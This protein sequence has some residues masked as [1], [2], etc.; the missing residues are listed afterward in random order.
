MSNQEWMK[1]VKLLNFSKEIIYENLDA[2]IIEF[3]SHYPEYGSYVLNKQGDALGTFKKDNLTFTLFTM[4]RDNSKDLVYLFSSDEGICIDINSQMKLPD[5]LVHNFIMYLIS[6][7]C[8]QVFEKKISIKETM[9]L[10]DNG[11]V[12]AL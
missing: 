2:D 12:E 7:Y 4:K 3:M 8:N 10:L 6:R 9:L 11:V 5:N 1:Q